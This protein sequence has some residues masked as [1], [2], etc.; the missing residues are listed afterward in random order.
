MNE[1]SKIHDASSTSSEVEAVTD[2]MVE[3]A[4]EAGDLEQLQVWARQGVRVTTGEPLHAPAGGGFVEVAICLVQ[5]PGADVNQATNAG[6]TALIYAV[7]HGNLDM[8]RCLV[9]HG[10]DVD[11]CDEEGDKDTAL[12]AAA[13]EGKLAIV[14]C[15]VEL[16]ASIEAVDIHGDTA[17][18]ACTR[19]GHYLTMHGH[20]STMQFLLEHAGANFDCVRR[21]GFC[22]WFALCDCLLHDVTYFANE[23]N[24]AALTPLLR[25]MVLRGDP[26]RKK[27]VVRKGLLLLSPENVRVVQEGARLRVRLSAYLATGPLGRALPYAAAPAPGPSAQ[28]HGANHYR[29]ALGHEA[30]RGPLNR[31]ARCS[32][33]VF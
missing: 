18:L 1:Y 5:E 26:P 14:R 13:K 15:L 32:P 9:E 3:E 6:I 25:V 33:V 28:L 12:L 19:N 17:L 2:E 31:G 8:V 24:P 21:A 27:K 22:I 10:A 30:G 29:G 7:V 20:Y 4:S 16:G 23:N 11:K